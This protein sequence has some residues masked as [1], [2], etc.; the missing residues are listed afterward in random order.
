MS[1]M[2]LKVFL[3]AKILKVILEEVKELREF[4]KR[5]AAFKTKTGPHRLCDVRRGLVFFSIN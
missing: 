3:D 5:N 2:G 1:L 4:L